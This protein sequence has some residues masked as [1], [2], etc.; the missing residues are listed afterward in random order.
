MGHAAAVAR[1]SA[2]LRAACARL[3]SDSDGQDGREILGG[4][5]ARTGA[6]PKHSPGPV[7]RH[8]SRVARQS[9]RMIL[10]HASSS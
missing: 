4:A 6:F 8:C 2:R 9:L 5:I 1:W 7:R 3:Q 10:L